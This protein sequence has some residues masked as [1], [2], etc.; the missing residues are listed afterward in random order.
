MFDRIR[1][2]LEHR[3]AG[4]ILSCGWITIILLGIID[5]TTGREFEFN[6]FYLLPL[7]FVTWFTDARIG[8]AT[9]ALATLVWGLSDWG[10]ISSST[11]IFF[12]IW[13]SIIEF[14]FYL[15]FT[16][17]L[18]TVRNRTRQLEEMAAQDPLT[19][20]ANRR[21]FYELLKTEIAR[22]QRYGEN[23][24]IAYIDID[25]FKTINDTYGHVTGD[26]LLVKVVSTLR[27]NMRSADMVA[28]IGGDEF[29]MLLPQ[30]N[31]NEAEQALKKMEQRL[32]ED[33]SV[34]GTPVTFSI[35]VLTFNECP[36]SVEQMIH[37]ADAVMYAVKE[38]GKDH[39]RFESWPQST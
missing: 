4:F 18:S 33:V 27:T 6:I 21:Y 15:F 3:S 20:A 37:A 10:L 23:I 17:L 38:K 22:S 32:R 29:V 11:N 34:N 8:V 2:F 5:R 26:E 25:D 13:N 35:G 1:A 36:E 12:Q 9:S 31:V 19:G 30:T 24:S 7:L 28:R 39:I 16:L 14:S